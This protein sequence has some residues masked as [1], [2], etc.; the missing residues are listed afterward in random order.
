MA[1]VAEICPGR[2]IVGT[3]AL[4]AIIRVHADSAGDDGNGRAVVVVAVVVISIV[5]IGVVVIA[6]SV[7]I[8]PAPP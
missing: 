3:V 7:V 1:I 4:R 6:R 5:V 8:I 2:R